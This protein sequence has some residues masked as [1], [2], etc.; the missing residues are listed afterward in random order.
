LQSDSVKVLFAEGA[1][2]HV[3]YKGH[4]G[5]QILIEVSC[6]LETEGR[7]TL[8]SYDIDGNLRDLICVKSYK[9]REE[10]IDNIVRATKIIS[11]DNIFYVD[12]LEMV[13]NS[14]MKP[15]FGG[16]NLVRKRKFIDSKGN[17][18]MLVK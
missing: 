11:K 1:N 8:L 17:F 13:H 2:N 5:D 12:I 18:A 6:R 9:K 14:E 10:G 16:E 4:I 15:I 3:S 7:I